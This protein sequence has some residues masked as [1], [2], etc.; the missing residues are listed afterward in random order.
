MNPHLTPFVLGRFQMLAA[1]RQRAHRALCP[2]TR[3]MASYSERMAKTGR[4]ISPHVFIYRFPTIAVS[5]IMVRVSGVVLTAGANSR[6][7]SGWA[8]ATFCQ[9][10]S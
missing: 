7:N 5:S 1:L 6:F 8:L 2:M 10:A 3:Q 9:Q 4:P